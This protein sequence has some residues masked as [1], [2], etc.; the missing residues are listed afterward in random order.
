MAVAPLDQVRRVVRYAVSE[1]PTSKILMGVP[2]YGY[3]WMLPYEQG[4]SRAENI[5]NQ[6]AVLR[7]A[8]YGAE[9]RFD[10]TAQSPYFEYYAGGNRHVV[11]FEDVRSVEA[12]LALTDEFDLLGVGYWNI[13]RRFDQNWAL[14]AARYGIV[15][16][17]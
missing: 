4:V 7:A 12:K 10:E 17:V 6:G 2:N 11:W 9:I 16:V 14:L 13:M 15:K 5:G 3:D 8:R 1:I